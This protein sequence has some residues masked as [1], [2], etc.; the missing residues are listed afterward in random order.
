MAG[1]AF[2]V[3]QTGSIFSQKAGEHHG[4]RLYLRRELKQRNE[5]K[6]DKTELK[7]ETRFSQR[8]FR[9]VSSIPFQI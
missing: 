8:E 2:F 7:R 5:R 6:R 9:S 4:N 1:R 3:L